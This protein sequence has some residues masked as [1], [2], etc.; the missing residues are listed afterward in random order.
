MSDRHLFV[1]LKAF[2]YD[3]MLRLVV[4]VAFVLSFTLLSFFV[5]LLH[6]LVAFEAGL[7]RMYIECLIPLHICLPHISGT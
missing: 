7:E 2:S 1:T 3:R 5:C 6:D 4:V